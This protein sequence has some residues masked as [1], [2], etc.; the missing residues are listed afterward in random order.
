M[1]SLAFD[2]ELG[3]QGGRRSHQLLLR[4]RVAHE[5]HE[6]VDGRGSAWSKLPMPFCAR[7]AC[8]APCSPPPQATRD[9]RLGDRRWRPCAGPP[10]P[11]TTPATS[12]AGGQRRGTVHHQHRVAL[13]RRQQ[14]SRALAYLA[15][16]AS[17]MMSIGL[18]RDHVGR[19]ERIER[20]LVVGDTGPACRR[21][22]RAVGG[23]HAGA[24]TVGQ[25]REPLA[26][27]LGRRA[28]GF[29]QRRKAPRALRRARGRRAG[30]R[31]CRQRPCRRARRCAT[32]RPWRRWRS[33]RP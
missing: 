24:A 1:R 28:T 5:L 26:A 30:R 9:D 27:E 18:P 19:Q 3:G 23:E 25:D 11:M 20:A 22:R 10:P 29:R 31:R 15:A 13:R 21:D 2:V 7:T 4:P 8:A 32:A 17:P 12:V 16:S 14:P 6:A 33:D